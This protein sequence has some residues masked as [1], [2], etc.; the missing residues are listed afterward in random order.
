MAE[1]IG[2]LFFAETPLK[3]FEILIFDVQLKVL[4]KNFLNCFESEPTIHQMLVYQALS[5]A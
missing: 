2:G 1:S 4:I 5:I 3:K